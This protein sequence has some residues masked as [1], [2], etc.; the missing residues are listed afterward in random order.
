MS[1]TVF[2]EE[3][4]GQ[5]YPQTINPHT[6][7]ALVKCQN[8][9]TV[10]VC[11]HIFILFF[12]FLSSSAL[13]S[14]LLQSLPSVS[15]LDTIV[16]NCKTHFFPFCSTFILVWHL[17]PQSPL[18]DLSLSRSLLHKVSISSKGWEKAILQDHRGGY[19]RSVK[20]FRV[21]DGWGQF[22]G[23][24][25]NFFSLCLCFFLLYWL[26]TVKHIFSNSVSV[27]VFES[28]D[29]KAALCFICFTMA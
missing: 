29:I 19:L 3:F 11:S 10:S 22:P 2:F 27:W 15:H 12:S 23:Q 25:C 20:T 18:F 7:T 26:C 21:I 8:T 17:F 1:G 28:I 5:L 16:C 24:F 4:W 14:S 6:Q 9:V 13:Y